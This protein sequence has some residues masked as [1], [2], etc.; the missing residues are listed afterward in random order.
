MI[1][2][3]VMIIMMLVVNSIYTIIDMFLSE[4]EASKMEIEITPKFPMNLLSICDES[5]RIG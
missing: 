1:I 4:L 3:N 2:A 5:T